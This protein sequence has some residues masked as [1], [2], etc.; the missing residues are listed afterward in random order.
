MKMKCVDE[1]RWKLMKIECVAP[2]YQVERKPTCIG[3]R[4]PNSYLDRQPLVGIYITIFIYL[5]L[6]FGIKKKLV[7][8]MTS[9]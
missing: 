5:L 8:R 1:D 3:N 9:N 7:C 6:S 2:I 4:N